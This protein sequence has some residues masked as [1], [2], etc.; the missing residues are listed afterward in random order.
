MSRSARAGSSTTRA[1]SPIVRVVVGLVS[2]TVLIVG[3]VVIWRALREGVGSA[4]GGWGM[5]I[6]TAVAALLAVR[7]LGAAIRGTISVRTR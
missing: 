3:L 2:A 1:L 7:A 5:M 4:P 6:V